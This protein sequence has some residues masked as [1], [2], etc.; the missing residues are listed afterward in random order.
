MS[1]VQPDYHSDDDP[2]FGLLGR[3][4]DNWTA[5]P[6]WLVPAVFIILITAMALMTWLTATTP[7]PQEINSTDRDMP[8]ISSTSADG[9]AGGMGLHHNERD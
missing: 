1:P 4:C 5:P 7:A 6:R 3:E 2:G 8:H 9:S